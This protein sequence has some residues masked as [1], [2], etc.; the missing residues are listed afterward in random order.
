MS[1]SK[2]FGVGMG[3]GKVQLW[4]RSLGCGSGLLVVTFYLSRSSRRRAN[5]K[6]ISLEGGVRE[7]EE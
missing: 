7:N 5:D 6:N 4:A 1:K 3:E 2:I